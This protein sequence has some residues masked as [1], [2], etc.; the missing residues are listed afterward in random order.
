MKKLKV[1]LYTFLS[2]GFKW[3]GKGKQAKVSLENSQLWSYTHCLE[4]RIQISMKAREIPGS[5]RENNGYEVE[6]LSRAIS[7]FSRLTNKMKS[8]QTSHILI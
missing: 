2:F 3:N 5:G 6:K 1:R 7:N 8:Q 4:V